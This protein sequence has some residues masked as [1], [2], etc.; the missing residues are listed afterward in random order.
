MTNVSKNT[1]H[2]VLRIKD[3]MK[4]KEGIFSDALVEKLGKN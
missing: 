4:Y 1:T 2:F 3:N